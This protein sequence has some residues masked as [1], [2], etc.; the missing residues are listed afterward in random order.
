M[1][2]LVQFKWSKNHWILFG[3]VL[4]GAILR[5][6]NYF[7]IPFTHDEISAL[8]RTDFPNFSTLIEEGVKKNDFHPAGIQVFLYY[9][10]QLVGYSEWIV[11]LPFTLASIASIYLGF[12]I[13]KKW[14][15]ETVGL[16]FAV[17]LATTQYTVMYGTIARPYASGLFFVLVLVNALINMSQVQHFWRN[18]I[19]FVIAGTL[20][21]YNH[22]YSLF[23]AG[24]I[25]FIGVFLMPLKLVGKYILAVVPI[26]ILYLPHLPILSYQMGIGGVG[27]ENGWLGPPRD[28]FL[29]EY[30]SYLFHFS[31]WPIIIC[32]IIF[33]YGL[34]NADISRSY[35]KFLLIS[36]SIFF[37]PIALGYYYSVHINPIIQYSILI[38]SH[39]F[40]YGI[41]FGHFKNLSP[42]KNGI[43]ISVVVLVN[44]ST[45]IFTRKHFELY[46]SSIHE[47]VV[48]DLIDYR[49]K[50][51]NLPA[52][53]DGNWGMRKFYSQQNGPEPTYRK[54]EAFESQNRFI[55]YLDSV[56]KKSDHF[57][58]AAISSSDPVLI[59]IIQHFFPS[60][61][62]QNNYN[63][64]STYLF[65]KHKPSHQIE[66]LR[67]S[68]QQWRLENTLILTKSPDHFFIL[69]SIHEFGPAKILN[70]AATISHSSNYLTIRVPLKE[71]DSTH[72]LMIV[73][74]FEHNDSI[75]QWQASS[76]LHQ[77]NNGFC[78]ELV[79]SVRLFDLSNFK[80]VNLKIYVWNKTKKRIEFKDIIINERKGNP[81]QHWSN[82][83][84]RES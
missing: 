10:V 28:T 30:L 82:E 19:V 16:L 15:N 44:C 41:L 42:L 22:H 66:H 13:G 67:Y 72:E 18:W 48:D 36:C 27:G 61:E 56:S 14:R 83:P 4:L 70:Y 84:I 74:Q 20:C 64:G 59:P 54:L 63:G 52:T 34:F 76:S 47:K 21:A 6:Y 5:F 49:T 24:L 65:S 71:I 29:L 26:F 2:Q 45:L 31:I 38:F 3:I 81:Y 23:V 69:D 39:V 58:Y 32:G 50:T 33:I 77:L 79:H 57:Y 9:W 73:T 12:Q 60:I 46:Y 78:N 43:I 40:L 25:G 8:L 68:A 11:K 37:I 62:Q 1:T 53:I 55:S 75:F 51:P 35:L 17:F 7:D 80:K